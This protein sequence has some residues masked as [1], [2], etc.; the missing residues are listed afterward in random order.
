ME[1]LTRR[2]INKT[3]GQNEIE[4]LPTLN[5]AIECLAELEDK[6][7]SGQLVEIPLKRQEYLYHL[8]RRKSQYGVISW[9]KRIITWE[10]YVVNI[11]KRGDDGL[12]FSTSDQ[13]EARLKELRGQS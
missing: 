7:E 1:R 13:A 9:S 2:F 6:L 3:N 4:V 10:T 5:E 12:Y 8:F 11:V